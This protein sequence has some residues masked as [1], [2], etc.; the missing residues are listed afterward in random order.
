M[1]KK[2]IIAGIF[3]LIIGILFFIYGNNQYNYYKEKTEVSYVEIPKS[4][5]LVD[6]ETQMG[7]GTT[8]SYI[9]IF[10]LFIGILLMVI[11]FF[12]K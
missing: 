10:M 6:Y 11:G 8:I 3:L 7:V 1:R 12:F 2:I 4:E 5:N 9:G